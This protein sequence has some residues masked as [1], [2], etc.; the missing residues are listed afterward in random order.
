M[1]LG[2][3]NS[4]WVV[5]AHMEHDE[6]V[7]LGIADVFLHSIEVESLGSWVVVSVLLWSLSEKSVDGVVD[8]PCW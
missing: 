8:W 7:V 6:G 2:W 5:G 1:F 3:V 4:S